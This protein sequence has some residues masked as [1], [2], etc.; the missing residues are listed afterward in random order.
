MLRAKWAIGIQVKANFIE[1]AT[2]GPIQ[3][4]DKILLYLESCQDE[5]IKEE[6]EQT[7]G[8]IKNNREEAEA[9]V[10]KVLRNPK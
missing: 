8:W 6:I 5:V 2:I 9:H 10:L 1:A 3:T 7:V 4:I